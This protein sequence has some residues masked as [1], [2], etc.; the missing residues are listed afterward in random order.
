MHSIN[1]KKIQILLNERR[2]LIFL[3]ME[4]GFLRVVS[5]NGNDKKSLNCKE[6]KNIMRKFK[7]YVRSSADKNYLSEK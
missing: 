4:K 1:F 7:V 2:K 6:I 3:N 5:I